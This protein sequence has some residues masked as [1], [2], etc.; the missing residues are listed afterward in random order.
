MAKFN[1]IKF[2]KTIHGADE[3]NP[4]CAKLSEKERAVSYSFYSSPVDSLTKR[5]LENCNTLPLKC[6]ND[7]N[8]TEKFVENLK[9][10]YPMLEFEI[11]RRNGYDCGEITMTYRTK[12]KKEFEKIANYLRKVPQDGGEMPKKNTIFFCYD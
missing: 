1:W 5:I 2:H 11:A 10:Y 3:V 4:Q 9:L 8:L 12:N 7:S 6:N